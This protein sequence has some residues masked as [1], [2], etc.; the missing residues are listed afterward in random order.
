MVVAAELE[1]LAAERRAA[2]AAARAAAPVLNPGWPPTVGEMVQIADALAGDLVPEGYW[3]QV[4]KLRY[5]MK[6]LPDE[7]DDSEDLG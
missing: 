2:R 3:D 5:Q 1:R 4:R 7:A 6:P